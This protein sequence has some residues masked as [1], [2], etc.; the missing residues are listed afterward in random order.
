MRYGIMLQLIVG[1]ALILTGAAMFFAWLQNRPQT[2]D[3]GVLPSFSLHLHQ[4]KSTRI[5]NVRLLRNESTISVISPNPP[6]P[7]CLIS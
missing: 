5:I 4:A 2:A 6:A 1:T 7:D 3:V